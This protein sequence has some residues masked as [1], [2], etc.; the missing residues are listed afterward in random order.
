MTILE[1]LITM[2]IL[3][4]LSTLAV[5]SFIDTLGR[6]SSKSAARS[7]A[8]TFTL[9]RSEAIK[10]GQDVSICPTSDG[11]DCAADS[12]N[13]GWIVFIDANGDADGDTGS[14]DA[15]DR[16]IRVYEPLSGMDVTVA[17]PTD[18]VRYDSKGYGKNTALLRFTMCPLDGN[19][20]NARQIEVGLSG[21]ARF[22]EGG[23]GC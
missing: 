3:G 9:A 16:V 8:S 2:A 7:L 19:A 18:I 10:A 5:P 23:L 12:W 20:D 17:P 22:V 13:R 4:L 6:M 15:G 1:L 11:L 21:R 14:I